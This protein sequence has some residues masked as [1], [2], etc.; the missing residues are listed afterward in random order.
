MV[1]HSGADIADLAKSHSGRL[2]NSRDLVV[3]RGD[4]RWHSTGVTDFAE[5]NDGGLA[6]GRIRVDASK[7]GHKWPH[8]AHISDL[9]KRLGLSAVNAGTILVY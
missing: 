2:A 8:P 7:N 5:G 3:E 6:Q 4:Q 1:N 9:A